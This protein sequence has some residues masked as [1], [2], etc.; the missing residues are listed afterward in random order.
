MEAK[1]STVKTLE[2]TPQNNVR[3]SSP[4]DEVKSFP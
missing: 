3:I 4:S 1:F 2:R